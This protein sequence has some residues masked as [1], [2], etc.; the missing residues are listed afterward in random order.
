MRGEVPPE[1]AAK[2]ART[3]PAM[4]LAQQ[5][6]MK[7]LQGQMAT[8]QGLPA[9][10]LSAQDAVLM[11]QLMQ[12]QGVKKTQM[13]TD[14][15]SG[16]CAV[17][18]CPFAHSQAELDPSGD[19]QMA[20]IESQMRAID[21]QM[22]GI[23]QPASLELSKGKGGACASKGQADKGKGKGFIK[24]KLCNNYT[25]GGYCPRGEMCTFAHGEEEIGTAC[26]PGTGPATAWPGASAWSPPVGQTVAP[27]QW[28]ADG[29]PIGGGVSVAPVAKGDFKG[30]GK[31][32]GPPP[33]GGMIQRNIE[34]QKAEAAA[35]EEEERKKAEDWAK[36][37][38]Q[39]CPD[40]MAGF[41]G[42][43]DLC[44]LAHGPGELGKPWGPPEPKPE[45]VPEVQL[46]QPTWVGPP[47]SQ[48]QQV[49]AEQP[50]GAPQGQQGWGQP[51]AQWGGEQAVQV[52]APAAPAEPT[53]PGEELDQP[54]LTEEEKELY[55]F[56]TELCPVFTR[57][58]WCQREDKCSFAHGRGDLMA[59]GQAKA[60]VDE[61]EGNS[62]K[63]LSTAGLEHEPKAAAP[64]GKGGKGD[65]KGGKGGKDDWGK[66]K[67]KDEWGKG[68]GKDEWGK[69]GG[70]DDWGKGWGKDD[71]G[72]GGG[73]DWWG[74]KGMDMW[75]GDGWG[76]GMDK[77]WG[78]KG[79]WGKGGGKDWGKG[80][81][82]WGGGWGMW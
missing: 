23:D 61:V 36:R 69:G 74:G 14:F 31:N 34:R 58:G 6:Q 46:V 29:Q 33:G 73:K 17:E 75:G 51:D 2:M 72:K 22:N 41:C 64:A 27:P 8:S 5:M 62:G 42:N 54:G 32:K 49:A 77:G 66:G 38:T 81:D 45:P 79:D 48:P 53:R 52:Q 68:W 4:N 20:D 55:N 26:A 60:I 71:W 1:P 7:V 76:K 24:T 21:A 30:K 44:T 12:G 63:A 80:M 57:D 37:K 40:F 56:K 13:C 59:P 18:N 47:G 11:Q 15:E 50:W 70:K 9:G 65:D 67:G 16:F 78:G 43:G 39:L 82:M 10:A 3:E 28:G 19:S 35:K 25:Q